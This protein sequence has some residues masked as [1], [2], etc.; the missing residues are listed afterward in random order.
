VGNVLRC[1]ERIACKMCAVQNNML[2]ERQVGSETFSG[3]H[4]VE[5][6]PRPEV[7]LSVPQKEVA[8]PDDSLTRALQDQ[9][10]NARS[11]CKY[12]HVTHDIV[13]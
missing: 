2:K 5:D 4:L 1:V 13:S 7:H 6:L 10:S 12:T 8:C 3:P 11:V 9:H